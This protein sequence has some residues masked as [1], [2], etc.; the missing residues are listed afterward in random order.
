MILVFIKQ[1]PLG[2]IISEMTNKEHFI[3]EWL[4][5]N[6]DDNESDAL[7]AW[8]NELDFMNQFYDWD[9]QKHD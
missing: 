4:Y 5:D 2:R 6:P 8:K 9:E 1:K 3:N 7:N